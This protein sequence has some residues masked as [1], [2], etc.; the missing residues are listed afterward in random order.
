MLAAITSE[1]ADIVRPRARN[2]SRRQS[3]KPFSLTGD[4]GFESIPLQ[5]GVTCEPDFRSV[6]VGR[7]ATDGAMRPPSS[8]L[9]AI[10]RNWQSAFRDEALGCGASIPDRVPSG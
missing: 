10:D 7:I 3:R 1:M 4:R 6:E 2:A 8:P 9:I 5:R